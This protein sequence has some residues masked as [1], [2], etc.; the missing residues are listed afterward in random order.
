MFDSYWFVYVG[1]LSDE[2]M[3]LSFVRHSQQYK[4]FVYIIVWQLPVCAQ[5]LVLHVQCMVE[6]VTRACTI[7]ISPLSVQAGNSRSRHILSSSSYNGSLVSWRVVCLTA[8][9]FKPLIFS[10]SGFA[11]SYTANVFIL[12]ILYDFC[13]LPA[14]FCY[15]L[16]RYGRLTAARKPWADVRCE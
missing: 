2:G 1:A 11:S 4:S 10:T 8:T 16:Y 13:L 6:Y 14:K 3:D 5:C 12:M 15:K 7:Y 9:K